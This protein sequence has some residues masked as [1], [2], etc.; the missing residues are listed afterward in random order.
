MLINQFKETVDKYSENIDKTNILSVCKQLGIETKQGYSE[1]TVTKKLYENIKNSLLF[2]SKKTEN[3]ITRTRL[4]KLQSEL[5]YRYVLYDEEP[6]E[7]LKILKVINDSCRPNFEYFPDFSNKKQWKEAIINSKNYNHFSPNTHTILFNDIRKDYPKDYDIA[8]SIKKLIKKGCK[9]DI[10]NSQI[11]INSGLEKVVEELD[12]KIKQYGGINLSKSLFNFLKVNG[13]YSTR[14]NRYFI[15]REASGISF[16][17]SPQIPF[18]YLLN[19]SLK[20]PVENKNTKKAQQK[21]NEIIDLSITIT[22]GV[23]GVQHYS[24]WEYYFKTGE[25]IIEFSTEISLWDSIFSIPQSKPKTALFITNELFS[26]IDNTEFIS[27]LNFSK[28]SLFSVIEVINN[29]SE[30]NNGP[31]IIYL[32]VV[33]KELKSIEKNVILEIL[34]FLS[35]QKTVNEEYILPSDYTKI[36]FFLKPLVKL[37]NTK[38]LIMDNS[39]CSPNYFETLVSSLRQKIKNLDSKLGIELEV[40]LQKELN[41]KN[42]KYSTGEYRIDGID[43]EC[44]LLIESSKSIVLIEFKKKVLTRKSKSGVDINILLDLSESLLSAQIQAGRTEIFLREKDEI[45][46]KSR[47]GKKKIINLNNRQIERVALTQ[48]EF[49]GFQDRNIVNQFLKSL[50]THSFGTYS[51]EQYIIKKFD[52]LNQMQ[53]IWIEQYDKLIKLDEHFSRFPFFNCWFLSLPQLL[54]I[55]NISTDNDSFYEIFRKTKHV[56]LNTLDWYREFDIATKMNEQ[57]PK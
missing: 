55:I 41:N 30:N 46:L 4:L 21:L 51:E 40:L 27:Y 56:T 3:K 24:H 52:K 12:N 18:G 10:E 8:L 17:Q 28:E 5:V 54:E 36:D 14:F 39:W 42:I 34:N 32:S 47:D 49:G 16:D 35:H 22:N 48:L 57:N 33:Y 6:I 19:L 20:Y 13:K 43:G 9:I 29:I 53:K 44:D 45:E 2:D 37:G 50:L 25:T 7:Y 15:T 31:T 38:F 11:R 26:F 1:R 23:Y